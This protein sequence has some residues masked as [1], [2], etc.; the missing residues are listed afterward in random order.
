MTSAAI[1]V[2]LFSYYWGN[3]TFLKLNTDSPDFNIKKLIFFYLAS[4][5]IV[6]DWLLVFYNFV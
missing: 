6:S 3:K 4:T 2:Y 1:K 5:T